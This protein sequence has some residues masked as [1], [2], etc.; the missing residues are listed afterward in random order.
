MTLRAIGAAPVEPKPPFSTSTATAMRG[1]SAGANA[2]NHEWSR[3][4]SGT[5]FSLYFSFWPTEK[6]C[7]V[8]VL[9]AM[10]YVMFLPAVAAAVPRPRIAP[11]IP[12]ITICHCPGD[13]VMSAP[14]S[15]AKRRIVPLTGSRTP[16][17]R[18]GL[19]DLPWFAS[20][21]V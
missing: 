12:S 11:S 7:A 9:P 21:D 8:P 20:I 19:N 17:T 13:A 2:M 6:T 18:R 1:A 10:S 15:G 16:L 3:R 4:R 14:F 5:V